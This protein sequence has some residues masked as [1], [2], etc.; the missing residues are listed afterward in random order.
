MTKEDSKKSLDELPMNYVSFDM[1][2]VVRKKSEQQ[3][4]HLTCENTPYPLFCT[5]TTNMD[6]IKIMWHILQ[7]DHM[8]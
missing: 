3:D 1:N 8:A 5:G 7:F 6:K 2:N 4:V